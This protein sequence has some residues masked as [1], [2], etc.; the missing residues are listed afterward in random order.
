MTGG[1]FGGCVV[2]LVSRGS[3]ARIRRGVLTRYREI[4][5]EAQAY[6]TSAQDG[7]SAHELLR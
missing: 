2:C 4:K 3:V 1:G 5:L 7:V 6:V